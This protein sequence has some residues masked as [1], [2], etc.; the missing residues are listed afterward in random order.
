MEPT[1]RFQRRRP[2]PRKRRRSYTVAAAIIFFLCLVSFAAGYLLTSITYQGSFADAGSPRPG[3][4]TQILV[5]GL[6]GDANLERDRTH[7]RSDVMML[8]SIDPRKKKAGILSIPRDTRVYI[9]GHSHDKI[10]HANVYGGPELSMKAVEKLL[11]TPVHYYVMLD[12]RAFRRIV[13]ILGG[14]E[15]D[16]PQRMYYRDPY[17]NLVIDLKPGRQVLDGDKALEFVRYRHYPNGDLGR[18]EAQHIFIKAL[19]SKIFTLKGVLKMPSMIAELSRYVDTNISPVEMLRLARVAI[20][21][22]GEDVRMATLPGRPDYIDGISYFRADS[23][24]ARAIID[25]LLA[26]GDYR[27]DNPSSAGTDDKG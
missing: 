14:I 26:D 2:E 7:T 16:V 12:F 10:A 19:I 25:E 11:D 8:V 21:L 27:A 18:I 23:T 9:P 4:R 20:G 24:Q 17:Q 3:G 1:P 6:D 13:D 15:V 22:G 5:L